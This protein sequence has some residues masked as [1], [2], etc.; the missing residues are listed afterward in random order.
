HERAA[1]KAFDAY[2][3]HA[4]AEHCRQAL[5]IADRLGERVPA[6]RRQRLEEMLGTATF[7]VSEFQA[8]GDAY[9]RAAAASPAPEPRAIDLPRASHSYIWAHSYERA[10][11][12]ADEA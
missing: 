12:T 4:A 10:R 7:Y 9:A 3:N 2:A 6:E 8:S 11:R 1:E 5:A